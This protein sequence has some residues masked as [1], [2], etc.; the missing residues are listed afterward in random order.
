MAERFSLDEFNLDISRWVGKSKEAARVFAAVSLQDLCE[1]VIISTPGPGNS[2]Q[3][4]PRPGTPTGFLR[5]SW[6]ASFG[7]PVEAAGEEDP[8]GEA[9]VSQANLT[10]AGL[11]IGDT[12]YMV[13]N[14]AYAAR[15]EYGFVG[16]DS[17]GRNISQTPRAW[18]RGAVASFPRI[19][20]EAARRIA[21]GDLGGRTG[22][23][24]GGG[25]TA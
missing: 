7:G 14:A 11:K 16:Q 21:D 6:H 13:N 4:N 22:G 1:L 24:S 2:T 17:L 15:L 18:V 23:I 3:A 19:A 25:F 10:L 8:T 9:S 12:F 5:G 20:E